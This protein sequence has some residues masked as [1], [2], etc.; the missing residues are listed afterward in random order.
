[1]LCV[2]RARAPTPPLPPLLPS[3]TP[4]PRSG[5]FL[6]APKGALAFDGVS[7]AYPSRPEAPILKGVSFEIPAGWSAALVGGSGSGKSTALALLQRLYAPTGGRVTL[8]GVD[9]SLLDLDW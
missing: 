6:P 2:V 8:D 1:M 4:A 9:V 7:F 5:A 3:A